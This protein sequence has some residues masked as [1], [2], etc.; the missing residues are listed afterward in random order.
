MTNRAGRDTLLF[1]GLAVL[2][3]L[4]FA[5]QGAAF[6]TR[7]LVEASCL[8][9]V[10]LGLTIQWGY[11]GLFNVGTMGFIAIAAY[12]TV[13][14]SFPVNGAFWTSNGP[15]LLGKT[16]LYLVVGVLLT[17][18]MS[19]THR[20]GLP[21]KI[22]TLLA[23]IAGAATYIAVSGA[24]GQAAAH[25]EGEAGFVGGFG[26]PVWIGWLGG[27]IVAGALGW[28]MGRITLGLRA[29]YMAIATLGIAEIVKA[30]L[31]NADWLTRGTLT[32]SPLPWPVPTPAEL[33]FVM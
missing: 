31:K 18:A 16:A 13:L 4:V 26:L 3:A 5:A 23:L 29:D 12:T 7:M 20:L 17:Y 28:V 6:G 2:I 22:R 21:K 14:V 10:A 25:I 1:A 33:G 27:G 30:Y 32:V 8:A 15:A 24:L 9:I 19:Q 11:A